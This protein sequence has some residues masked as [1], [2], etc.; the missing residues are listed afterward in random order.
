MPQKTL[1]K[2][3]SMKYISGSA[4]ALL[5]IASA[6]SHAAPLTLDRLYGAPVQK[7]AAMLLGRNSK[8]FTE[9]SPWTG[10]PQNH[11]LNTMYLFGMSFYA[12]AEK[13]SPLVCTV[14]AAFV[15]LDARAAANASAEQKEAAGKVIWPRKPLRLRD[16]RREQVYFVAGPA[17][18]TPLIPG[19]KAEPL[20]PAAQAPRNCETPISGRTIFHAPSHEAAI[21]A[22]A[23]LHDVIGAA[24][25]AQPLPFKIICERDGKECSEPRD[26]LAALPLQALETVRERQCYGPNALKDCTRFDLANEYPSTDSIVKWVVEVVKADGKVV[27]V[28]VNYTYLPIA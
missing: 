14:R 11:V 6:A 16:V 4:A 27:E 24:A 18:P 12:R 21:S 9:R 19:R 15:T 3:R 13:I 5:F 25:Q 1:T 8:D 17:I 23:L 26:A 10:I 20:S 7:A 28:E 22:V 2:G